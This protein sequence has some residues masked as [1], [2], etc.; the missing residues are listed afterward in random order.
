MN[1]Y[2]RL[3][4]VVPLPTDLQVNKIVNFHIMLEAII[5]YTLMLRNHKSVPT[6]LM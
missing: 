6:S 3:G 4:L 1:K 5:M 2:T